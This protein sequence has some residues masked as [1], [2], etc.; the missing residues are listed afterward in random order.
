MQNNYNTLTGMV[1]IYWIIVIV[2]ECRGWACPCPCVIGSRKIQGTRKGNG[3]RRKGYP[4]GAPLHQY[5]MYFPFLGNISLREIL[6]WKDNYYTSLLFV[7]FRQ[8][9]ISCHWKRSFQFPLM[10]RMQALQK[11]PSVL[12]VTAKARNTPEK[13]N[14]LLKTSV[15]SATN[16]LNN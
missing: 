10:M 9:Y 6:L 11:W 8:Y 1:I 12:S 2:N 15:L 5:L 14:T 3:F 16:P 13:R 4:Q 7:L